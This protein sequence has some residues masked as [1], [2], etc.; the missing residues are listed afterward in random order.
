VSDPGAQS[1][2]AVIPLYTTDRPE[3]QEVVL[4]MRRVTDEFSDA[5]SQRIIIGEIYLPLSRLMA[6]YGREEDGILR[7]VQLPFNFQ[8]IGAPW[9]RGFIDRIVREYEAALPGSGWPNWVLG[10]HDKPRI[11]SRVGMQQARVAAMLLLT[12]RGTPTMYY[13]DEI[14]MQDVP[15]PPDEVQDPFEKNEPR[16]GL[17]RDPERTPMQWDNS[18]NAGFTT[19]RPWLR[20]GEDSESRNVAA[21]E[22]D[23]QSILSLYKRLIVFRQRYV[24]LT[25]GAYEPI[26]TEG[27]LLA[28]ARVHNTEHLLVTANFGTEPVTIPAAIL[29]P[30]AIVLMSTHLDRTGPFA[31]PFVLR[32]NEGMI[33]ALQ[34]SGG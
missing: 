27:Q 4:E 15:V 28:F 24:E 33:V 31:S 2:H 10:N 12:L 21:L 17:G 8:L 20:L 14:G 29:P 1:S 25:E 3:V 32:P 19:G 34:S 6:Y 26:S 13:G 7:G 18:P 5:D 23:P 16:K 30:S 22:R 11:A 9:E